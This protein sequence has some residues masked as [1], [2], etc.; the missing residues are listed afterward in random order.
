MSL[1]GNTSE[2][3]GGNV[4]MVT[5]SDKSLLNRP[6]TG[7]QD[8]NIPENNSSSSSSS[9]SNSGQT[10]NNCGFNISPPKEWI[11][12]AGGI[13]H[14][15]KLNSA[16]LLSCKPDAFEN[17]YYVLIPSAQALMTKPD[18]GFYVTS[19][20]NTTVGSRKAYLF[21]EEHKFKGRKNYELVLMVDSGI[22]NTS[23]NQMDV[24]YAYMDGEY[25]VQYEA[26]LKE[27]LYSYKR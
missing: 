23:K 2:A 12:V 4:F 13:F 1:P 27:A 21:R 8:N 10:Q 5:V 11:P 25:K 22:K 18:S 6:Q 3:E 16:I 14:N 7:N 9:A 19:A 15:V 24:I 26:I 20:E 17:N